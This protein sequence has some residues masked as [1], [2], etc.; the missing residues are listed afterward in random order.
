MQ[1]S[2]IENALS[3][4]R[5]YKFCLFPAVWSD[6]AHKGLCKW[7]SESS[8]NPDKIK[9]WGS[10]HPD[11]AYF[12]VNLRA[13]GYTVV[14]VDLKNGKNGL[15]TLEDL[16]L[17]HGTIPDTLTAQTP[18]DGIHYFLNGIDARFGAN[19][20]GTGVDIPVMVP[21]PNQIVTG[22]GLYKVISDTPIAQL[23]TWITELAGKPTR[24][25]VEDREPLID[26]D[27]P[28]NIQSAIDFLRDAEPAIEGAG[29]NDHTYRVCCRVRDIGVS[30][31]VC[32]D[33]LS[34]Y[35]NKACIPPWSN[36]ELKR[37]VKNAYT[38]AKSTPGEMDATQ[39]F[40][41]VTPD[42]LIQFLPYHSLTDKLINP[43]WIVKNYFEQDT[44]NLLYGD[45]GAYKSFMAMDIGLHIAS[46]KN[47]LDQTTI[48]GSVFYLAGEGH[49]GI[50]RRL[51]A[52]KQTHM[53]NNRKLPFY[54]SPFAIQLD[55][56]QNIKLLIESVKAIDPDPVLIIIDTLATSFGSGDENS[57]KDMNK[58]ILYCQ[59][60]RERLSGCSIMV[61]HHTGHKNKE[62]PRGAYALMGGVDA[63]YNVERPEGTFTTC[64][65]SAGKM[66]DGLPQPD[67]WFKAKRVVLGVDEDLEDVTS[68]YLKYMPKYN[69]PVKI[70]K[71]RKNEGLVYEL[72]KDNTSLEKVKDAFKARKKEEGKAYHRNYFYAAVKGLVAKELIT[73][74]GDEVIILESAKT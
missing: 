18:N 14:D 46:G 71:L 1:K 41:P 42:N 35:F 22:K 65:R 59:K 38:Y 51:M 66:K 55:Q 57:T 8:S 29:G 72:T 49:G 36:S 9:A 74:D 48:H 26:L 44:L 32:L 5:R 7:G 31:S 11:S 30:K 47:W 25:E 28:H 24:I 17:L 4:M 21:L 52:W 16:A 3:M 70:K 13:S 2:I 34:R 64:L 58:F 27:Q 68:L 33:L 50:R 12:C 43:K 62:R 56:A 60:L 20:L 23:P 19:R 73:V 53:K 6:N 45:S 40:D 54:V 69:E 61:V 10:M 15:S 63:Y 39:D 37:L 67:T